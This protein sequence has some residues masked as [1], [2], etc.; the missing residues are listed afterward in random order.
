MHFLLHFLPDLQLI[1]ALSFPQSCGSVLK[2][3]RKVLH[4]YMVNLFLFLEVKEICSHI[5]A[6]SLVPS[7]VH[8]KLLQFL[9]S[10]NP[11][12]GQRISQWSCD[13]C[14]TQFLCQ[15]LGVIVARA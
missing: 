13:N 3:R 2:V 11:E 9:S 5:T 12:L 1:W 15:Q 6:T 4:G 8:T 7:M 10:K 14:N